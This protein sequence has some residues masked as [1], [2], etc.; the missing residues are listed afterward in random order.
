MNVKALGKAAWVRYNL[1]AYKAVRLLNQER[2]HVRNPSAAGATSSGA[3][4]GIGATGGFSTGVDIGPLPQVWERQ[5][6]VCPQ[7][8][9]RPRAP[10]S[11]EHNAGWQEPRPEPALGTGVG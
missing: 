2:A 8:T 9:S 4:W 5:L 6:C 11:M 1:A 7:A 3:L 10:V